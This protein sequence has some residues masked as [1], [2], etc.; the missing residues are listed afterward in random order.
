MQQTEYNYLPAIIACLVVVG[1]PLVIGI[2]TTRRR[3]RKR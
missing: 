1:I 3:N 2:V